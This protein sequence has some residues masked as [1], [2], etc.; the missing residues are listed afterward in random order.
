MVAKLP[1]SGRQSFDEWVEL[2]DSVLS[3][4]DR[5]LPPPSPV[6]GMTRFSVARTL[7]PT[8]DDDEEADG[9]GR[10]R[11][12]KWTCDALKRLKE[13]GNPCFANLPSIRVRSRAEDEIFAFAERERSAVLLNE[14]RK[15]GKARIPFIDI[16]VGRGPSDT[17]QLAGFGNPYSHARHVSL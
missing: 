14:R 15:V 1:R 7:A 9:Y 16:R 2:I 5:N 4:H 12:L 6:S 3:Q 17:F 11:S 13:L 10:N 8:T